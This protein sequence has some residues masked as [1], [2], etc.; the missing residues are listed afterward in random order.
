MA[1]ITIHN[2]EDFIKMAAA[3]KLAA[4]ILDDLNQF[5]VTGI[6]TNKID[7]F[8][9]KKILQAGAKAAPLNYKG[10][11]KSVCTSINDVICHGIPN[12]KDILKDGDI[13]NVDITVILD[14]YYGDCS[15]MYLIGESF[16]DPN[17]RI[18][19]R[20]LCQV[21][22]D[23]MMFGIEA[24]KPG[25]SIFDIGKAIQKHAHR[26]SFSVVRDF[27]GHG[28]GKVFHGEPNVLHYYP[29][30]STRR[31]LDVTLEPGMFFTIEP[32]I[33]VGSWK[34][35]IDPDGWTA[36]TIDGSLSA[37]FEHTIGITENGNEIFTICR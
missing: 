1:K 21:T 13:I 12:D 4:S 22:Y 10:F 24:A 9:Q 18:L 34:S 35:K 11:P 26:N 2:K 8:C 6:S 31:F 36:R 33:N 19:E 23:C 17:K 25:R 32:M 7:I 29:D 15:R 30:S 20:K 3:G 27:C 37:Q 14:G 16:Q 5:I 28:I